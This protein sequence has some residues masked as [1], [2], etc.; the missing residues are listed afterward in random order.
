MTKKQ[1]H[2]DVVVVPHYRKKRFLGGVV[3][4]L[5]LILAG[6]FLSS[7]NTTALAAR[8]WAFGFI[9]VLVLGGMFLGTMTPRTRKVRRLD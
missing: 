2:F 5:A 9:V 7:W 6:M 1:K 4:G 8:P 3:L